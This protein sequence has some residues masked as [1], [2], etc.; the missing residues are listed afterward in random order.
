M[1]LTAELEAAQTSLREV[2]IKSREDVRHAVESV[3]LDTTRAVQGGILRDHLELTQLR[4]ERHE[5]DAQQKQQEATCGELQATVES[6]EGALREARAALE[7]ERRY[8][9]NFGT[10]QDQPLATDLNPTPRAEA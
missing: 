8:P 2:G 9:R 10:E 3:K 4:K 7:E 5:W 1:E 6:L